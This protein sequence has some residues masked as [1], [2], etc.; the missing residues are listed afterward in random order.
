MTLNC[1]L[2][3]GFDY[4]YEFVRAENCQELLCIENR[5]FISHLKIQYVRLSANHHVVNQFKTLGLIA[6]DTVIE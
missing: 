2:R 6:M 5:G 1:Q 4:H 3:S